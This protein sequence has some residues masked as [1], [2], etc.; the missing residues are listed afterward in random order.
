MAWAWRGVR[1]ARQTGAG[2]CALPHRFGSAPARGKRARAAPQCQLNAA[3]QWDTPFLP[4]LTVGAPLTL[5]L[6]VTAEF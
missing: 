2:R 5:L 6:S 4:G 1:L 3:A